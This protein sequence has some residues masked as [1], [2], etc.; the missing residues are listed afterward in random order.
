ME[1][2]F[3]SIL[4]E[5]VLVCRAGLLWLAVNLH[6]LF[7]DGAAF[8]TRSR[9]SLTSHA[10]FDLSAIMNAI[11]RGLSANYGSVY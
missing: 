3:K 10:K 7:S 2:S 11:L 1:G 4:G 5:N 8:N 9:S 6:H